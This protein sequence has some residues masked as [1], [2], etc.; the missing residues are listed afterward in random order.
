MQ[1]GVVPK[2]RQTWRPGDVF[3]IPTR[4][5]QFAIGQVI[6][7]EPEMMPSVNVALFDERYADIAEATAR[8]TLDP[9]TVFASLFV[10]KHH[11]NT[12]KWRVLGNRPIEVDPASSLRGR[13]SEAGFS[14]VEILGANIINE[15]VDAFYGLVPWDD[16]HDPDFLD[17]LLISESVKPRRTFKRR[18][19][20][21]DR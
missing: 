4:D 15:F 14:G 7:H 20:G 3:V 8:M 2:R 21:D 6:G 5:A 18:H 10:T 1:V 12:G 17:S 16:W 9:Q 13:T 19:N 11:L